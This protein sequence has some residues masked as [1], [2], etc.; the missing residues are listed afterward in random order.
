[1]KRKSFLGLFLMSIFVGSMFL[2]TVSAVTGEQPM[3]TLM[4]RYCNITNPSDGATVSGL[5]TITVSASSTPVIYI[6]GVRVARSYS[7]NW[8]TT[9]YSDGA[10]SIYARSRGASDRI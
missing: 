4:A 5:V 7:Y 10:H 3:S 8:D 6:D 9:A 1:M 2:G